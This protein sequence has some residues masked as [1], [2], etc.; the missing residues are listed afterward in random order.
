[1]TIN[2][3]KELKEMGFTNEQIAAICGN[4]GTIPAT[5]PV[6]D[7]KT[8]LFIKEIESLN[9]RKGVDV[10]LYTTTE[11]TTKTGKKTTPVTSLYAEMTKENANVQALENLGFKASKGFSPANVKLKRTTKDLQVAFLNDFIAKR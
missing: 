8:A 6:I 5:T 11:K 3:I 2:E 4:D 7:E 9:L 1:M 10:F